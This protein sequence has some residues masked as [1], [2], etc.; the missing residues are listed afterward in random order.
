MRR[1]KPKSY[2][3]NIY[4]RKD[5]L[6]IIVRSKKQIPSKPS[7]LSSYLDV[8]LAY[9]GIWNAMSQAGYIQYA[10]KIPGAE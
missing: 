7:K 3:T 8:I 9:A 5:E 1:K 4:W 10:E 6:I 2:V